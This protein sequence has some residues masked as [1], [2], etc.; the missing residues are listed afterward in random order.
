MTLTGRDLDGHARR[1]RRSSGGPITLLAPGQVDTTTCTGDLHDHPGRHRRRHGHQPGHRHRRPARRQHR[2]RPRRRRP[3]RCRRPR[4]STWSRPARRQ[5]ESGDGNAPRSATRLLHV[6]GDQHRQ[7][8]PHRRRPSTTRSAGVTTRPAPATTARARAAHDDLHRHLHVTQAD[9]DAGSVTNLATATGD[10]SRRQSTVS[11]PTT[12]TATL[13]QAAAIDAG[14]DRTVDRPTTATAAPRRRH[15]HLQFA[16][17]NTGNVTLTGV[18]RRR[19][20]RRRDARPARR[21]RSRPGDVD[22][23]H[24]T[25]TITQADIDA[26]S[27]TNLADA[28]ATRPTARRSATPTT[29]TDDAAADRVDRTWSRPAS[30]KTERRRPRRRRAT[31][32]DLHVRVTNTGN[33]TLTGVDRRRRA[34]AASTMRV[35]RQPPL[36]PGRLDRPAPATY[37]ITQADVDAGSVTNLA[38]A[39]ATRRPVGD[40]LRP[41]RRDRA[42]PQAAR[43]RP[44]K[45][46]TVP[47]RLRR[48]TILTGETIG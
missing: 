31:T 26:G 48:P 27:V 43:D 6:R 46:R 34:R 28:A 40:R 13:P 17:T 42:L 23:L 33:V 3:S 9:I 45:D 37:T 8:D 19:R 2:L 44:G 1:G 39:T 35:R 32:I 20:A 38:T 15:D 18:D 12:T 11:D 47:P 25:Y 21:R 14:Q 22:D 41:R 29:T 36:A 16:V 5:D 7:R 10:P 4:R 30:S 24:R